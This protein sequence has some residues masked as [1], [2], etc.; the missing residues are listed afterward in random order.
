V[1]T[2]VRVPLTSW[3]KE[4]PTG[5]VKAPRDGPVKPRSLE[6]QAEFLRLMERAGVRPDRGGQELVLCPW[7]K[8]I[9]PSLSVNWPACVFSCKGC[10]EKG[11]FKRLRELVGEP[12]RRETFV[13]LDKNSSRAK[14][15]A[16]LPNSRRNE[17]TAIP[18]S[19][20]SNAVVIPPTRKID[21]EREKLRLAHH[22]KQAG[23]TAYE[24]VIECHQVFSRYE[25]PA[26]GS[27]KVLASSCG[28]R[29]CVACQPGRLRADFKRHRANIPGRLNLYVWKPENVTNVTLARRD[30][31]DAFKRWRR[32]QGLTAGLYG[33]RKIPHGYDVLLVLP[34]ENSALDI[35][36]VADNVDLDAAI[37]WYTQKFLEEATGWRTTEEMLDLLAAVKGQRRFQGWGEWYEKPA[38]KTEE[39]PDIPDEPKKLG[40]V[41]GGGGAKREP[42]TCDQCGTRMLRVGTSPTKEDA[43]AWVQARPH[44]N[45]HK[46]TGPPVLRRA[47]SSNGKE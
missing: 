9:D 32:E 34:A 16:T 25:C 30:V 39:T 12:L 43:E 28:Q 2:A 7:H 33:L 26:D 42:V 8:D 45:G 47:M 10:G 17:G 24:K 31:S 37:D 40:K 23:L 11:G 15:L 46:P 29:L 14:S 41:S 18:N 35:P 38:Q 6:D 19:P 20:P 27:R 36:A 4:I 3:L 22:M 21:V 13:R 1:V 44:Q 5:P